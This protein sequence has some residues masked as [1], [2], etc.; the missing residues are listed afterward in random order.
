MSTATVNGHVDWTVDSSTGRSNSSESFRFLTR[1][2]A[3][4]LRNSRFDLARCRFEAVAG[5]ILAKL[6]HVHGLIPKDLLNQEQA[7]KDTKLDLDQL[8]AQLER[9]LMLLKD[10]K[11]GLF[12]WCGFLHGKLSLVGSLL[13]NAGY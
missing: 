9:L 13:R 3:E 8:Q 10:R 7:N 11:P 5:L 6:A 4:L 1:E 12:T 2:V